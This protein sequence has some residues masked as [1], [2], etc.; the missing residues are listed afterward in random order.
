MTPLGAT[1][2]SQLADF[3]HEHQLW[4]PGTE[5]ALVGRRVLLPRAE[6]A[7]SR[8]LRAA[9]AEVD[10]VALTRTEPLPF[11]LP[12]RM[13]WLVLTSPTSVRVLTDTGADLAGLADRIAA[14]GSSTAAAVVAAGGVVDLVPEGTS[15]ADAL[16][17]ALKEAE[18]HGASA[19]L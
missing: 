5:P 18:P 13:D 12:G 3:H 6:G 8:A 11:A 4:A 15:D 10:A 2:A 17:A 1:R 19:L 9:G 14:V 7:L 16:L